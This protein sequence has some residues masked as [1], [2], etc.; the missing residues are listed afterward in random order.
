M[1]INDHIMLWNYAYAYIRVM[2]VRH[3]IMEPGEQ[4]C[5]YCLPSSAFLFITRGSA[6]VHL[7]GAASSMRRFHVLHTGKGLYLDI[8]VEEMFEYYMIL[9]KAILPLPV[10]QELKR[11]M[12]TDNP[13]QV[14]YSF[15]PTTQ[16]HYIAAWLATRLIVSFGHHACL[17]SDIFSVYFHHNRCG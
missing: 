17:L 8:A 12:E 4:L 1:N 14:R 9:Y 3:T 11:I 5:S 15:S 16:S 2:D 7:D 6:Q 13:F 10:Q